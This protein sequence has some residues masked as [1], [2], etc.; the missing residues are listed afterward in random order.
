L[1]QT[2]LEQ[3]FYSNSDA[4]PHAKRLIGSFWW[5]DISKLMTKFLQ[6]AQCQPNKGNSV[7]FW[8]DNWSDAALQ[9]KFPQLH[10]YA[11]KQNCSIR[12][13]LDKDI[14]RLFYLPL[15]LQASTQLFELQVLLHTRRWDNDVND[16][17]VYTWGS[18]G[19]TNKKAYT[20]LRGSVDASPCFT[21]FGPLAALENISSSFGYCFV[22]V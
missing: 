12:F 4:P 14:N 20:F 16:S 10:S 15:S 17:W 21:G 13:F 22:I 2:Y 19:F 3:A 11:K 18:N 6:M 8:G 5:K 9:S 1:G 7:L